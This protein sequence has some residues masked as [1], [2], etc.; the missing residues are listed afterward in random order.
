MTS[1]RAFAMIASIGSLACF[2]SPSFAVEAGDPAPALSLP[3]ASGEIVTL[4]KLRGKIVFVDFWASWCGPC[5]YSFPWMAE[6]Q[7]KYGAS[8]FAVVAIN[9]DKRRG[10]AERFLQTMPAPFT[11]VFDP[12]GVTPTA[13]K[14]KAMPSSYVID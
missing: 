11:V 3:M 4:D 13:W 12:V 7:K 6:M 1:L 9:V 5:R 2:I 10:D 14:V 8:G